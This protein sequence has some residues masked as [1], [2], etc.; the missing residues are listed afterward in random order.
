MRLAVDDPCVPRRGPGAAL[1]WCALVAA[2]LVGAR[3][4]SAQIVLESYV[5]PRPKDASVTLAPLLAELEAHGI[6]ALPETVRARARA[7]AARP[8]I[9]NPAVTMAGLT[10]QIGKATEL[11]Q[12]RSYRAAAGLFESA[13]ADALA[14][15]AVLVADPA[16]G[17]TAM[18]NAWIGLATCR[19]RLGDQAGADAAM[20]EV[21]RSF[22]NQEPSIRNGYGSEPAERYRKAAK[23]L[24]ARGA[25]QLVITTNDASALIYV[26]EWV[27]PQSAIL[28][29]DALPG[30]HRVLVKLPGTSGWRYDVTVEPTKQTQLDIDVR[31]DATVVISSEWVGFLFSSIG[32]ARDNVIPY[33]RRLL[34]SSDDNRLIIA[35]LTT[36][37][38]RPA[39][40]GSVFHVERGVHLR[41]YLVRL[42][43]HDDAAQLRMLAHALMDREAGEVL[44][45]SHQLVA[46]ADPFAPLPTAAGPERRRAPSRAK[47]MLLGGAVLA[48]GAGAVLVGLDNQG[49]CGPTCPTIYP[50]KPYGY[51]SFVL[52][53][54]MAATAGYWLYRDAHARSPS[55]HTAIGIAP[56]RSGLLV[57]ATKKF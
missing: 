54:A 55:E 19:A 34:A 5:G 57:I 23:Q 7:R 15:D 48:A 29:A 22:P 14:N 41:S 37:N 31:F 2:F 11:L 21:A 44:V 24:Q 28:E 16:E 52:A 35:T 42:G 36:W 38:D 46:I 51:A 56:A 26:D 30:V 17:H 40:L 49:H 10:E 8:G 39:V 45:R 9:I 25:G 53:G 47:W 27:R 12:N 33:G 43:G 13:I 4:A 6:A 18:M 20:Q 1:R 50:T 3:S 32:V